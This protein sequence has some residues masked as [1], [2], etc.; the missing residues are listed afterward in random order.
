MRSINRFTVLGNVGKVTELNKAVKVNIATNR[1]W[2]DKEG[3][4]VVSTDWVTVTVLDEKQAA[5]IS[6]NVEVGDAVYAEAR[7][8]N[9]TYEKDGETVY[10]TDVIATLFNRFPGA[11][12]NDE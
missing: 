7:I 3:K 2:K 1:R 5:W 4:A 6:E 12:S 11:G 10:T 9:R 8:S